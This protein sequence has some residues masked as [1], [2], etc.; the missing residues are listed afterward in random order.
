M[1]QCFGKFTPDNLILY[2]HVCDEC[3]GYFGQKLEL[4]LGRDSY[5]AIERLRHGLKP[6][7]SLKNRRRIRSKII[8]G[9]W[10]NVI[11]TEKLHTDASNIGLEKAV[12]A[13]FFNTATNEYDFFEPKDIP[14][15]R[16]LERRGYEL[17]KKM[18]WLVAEESNELDCLVDTL[19][20][21]GVNIKPKDE[22]IKEN[23]EGEEVKVETNITID[24]VIIRA[25]SKIAFNYLS[26]VAGKDFALHSEFNDV[27]R[28]VRYDEGDSRAFFT[29]T[30]SPVLYED[31]KLR[32]YGIKTTD[33]HLIILE[34]K[35]SDILCKVS[36]FNVNTYLVR[37]VAKFRGIWRPIKSGHHFA[38]RQMKVSKLAPISKKIMI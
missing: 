37:L 6:K 19:R 15:A 8:E 18:V 31:Q 27:R 9:K 32:K 20:E 22:L 24:R 11:V 23:I 28:F 14:N 29:V 34:W 38:V 33:G 3:N 1:P 10:K 5:E 13:G 30:T 21:K 36:L 17:K 7:E 16:E 35:G 12:Q 25:I 4:F 26:Y 2:D